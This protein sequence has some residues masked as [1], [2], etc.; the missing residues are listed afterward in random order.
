MSVSC[1]STRDG[2]VCAL[3]E[4]W[5]V[6]TC[7]PRLVCRG[8]DSVAICGPCGGSLLGVWGR[9]THVAWMCVVSRVVH[10]CIHGCA[11]GGWMCL[12]GMYACAGMAFFFEIQVFAGK[13]AHLSSNAGSRLL[14]LEFR[15]TWNCRKVPPDNPSLSGP[16]IR[17]SP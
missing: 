11:W 2:C 3:S 14:A 13:H 15:T 12:E 1:G 7:A 10:L 8:G 9:R 6:C 17:R 5:E 16:S 4:W